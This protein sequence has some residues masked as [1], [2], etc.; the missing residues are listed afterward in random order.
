MQFLRTYLRVLK[1]LGSEKRLAI[2]LVLCNLALAG[3]Q[4]AEPVLFGR[5]IDKLVSGQ[6]QN[7][8][9]QWDEL[10]PLVSAWVGFG[11]FT[12]GAAVIVALHADRLS[13]RRRLSMMS[14][15]FEHVLHQIGRAHV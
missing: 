13:H 14:E 4:F 1:L 2:I 12:I 11:L 7:R 8:V 10:I 6:A 15:F 3:A 5:I 9:L